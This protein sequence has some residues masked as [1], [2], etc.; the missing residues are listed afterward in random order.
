MLTVLVNISKKLLKKIPLFVYL[1]RQLWSHSNRKD[2]FATLNIHKTF[3]AFLP[4]SS[5]ETKNLTNLTVQSINQTFPLIESLLASLSIDI[6]IISVDEFSKRANNLQPSME[7]KIL[8]DQYGSDKAS[9]HNYHL[10]YGA[11]LSDKLAIKNILEVGMGT[12]NL[13]VASNMG[14]YGKPGASLRAFRD[15]CL[16][17]EIYGA[18]IDKRILFSEERIKTF[19]VDQT[20]VKTFK[21]L[22]NELFESFDLVIDDGL[23]SPN[24]NIATL[25][26]GLQI[27]KK[28]G[29]VIIEDIRV[30]SLSIWK[31]IYHLISENFEPFIIQ[32]KSAYI[33]AAQRLK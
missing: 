20:D 1:R 6:P 19:Y 32:S 9:I 29:W 11:V 27:I 8:F 28:N 31:V 10:V 12:I 15:F 30:E 2:Y 16:N 21:Q 33:F 4:S 22:K 18:D 3:P 13:D 7:L 26:F 5:G 14:I 25:D 23:H 17:A 24:A